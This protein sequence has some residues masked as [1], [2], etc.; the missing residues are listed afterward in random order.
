MP[1][2]KFAKNIVTEDLM[3]PFPEPVL[4]MLDKQE[5][6]GKHLDR[7]LMFGI[8]DSI[9]KGSFFSGCEWLWEL[10]DG[11]PFQIESAHSHDFDEVIG[12]IG[13]WRENP[14]ELG[15]EVEFWIGGEQHIITN[16]CLIFIPQK[17]EHCP[18]IFR[19]IDSPIFMFEA[20]NDTVYQKIR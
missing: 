4:K 6:E 19:R 7:T 8:N 20:G 12:L 5:K 1:E 18:L 2:S 9:V 16:T 10:K 13:S 15:G 3:P 17:V 11:K 14:R